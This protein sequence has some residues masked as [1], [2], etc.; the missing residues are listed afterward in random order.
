MNSSPSE[1]L[2]GKSKNIERSHSLSLGDLPDL[3]AETRSSA[4]QVDCHHLSQEGS[5]KVATNVKMK[6]DPRDLV[7]GT[8]RARAASGAAVMLGLT[9]GLSV[10]VVFPKKTCSAPT[11]EQSSSFIK[12]FAV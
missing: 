1:L 8:D 7:P 2:A 5:P 9:Q 10:L 4:L 11:A 3:G 6:G 12:S